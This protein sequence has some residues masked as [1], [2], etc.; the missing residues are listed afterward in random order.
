MRGPQVTGVIFKAFWRIALRRNWDSRLGCLQ[1]SCEPGGGLHS[2]ERCVQGLS[3]SIVEVHK[4][5]GGTV[6]CWSFC[7]LSTV[8]AIAPC[9][10]VGIVGHFAGSTQRRG[11]Q[12]ADGI[13]CS[14]I[15]TEAPTILP[16]LQEF[17]RSRHLLSRVWYSVR[18]T[19]ARHTPDMYALQRELWFHTLS[20]DPKDITQEHMRKL[21]DPFQELCT[22]AE[23]EERV[24]P[25]KTI[26]N[27]RNIGI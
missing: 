10:T 9:A 6:E 13:S 22:I 8:R 25:R 21:P 19:K 4:D 23:V 26:T 14:C 2:A 20:W 27:G 16:L 11:T 3:V 17:A 18:Y 5:E 12:T 15:Y 1:F 24:W 7:S